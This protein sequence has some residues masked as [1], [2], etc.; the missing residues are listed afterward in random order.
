MVCKEVKTY[1]Q[2]IY[3]WVKE[4]SPAKMYF[5]RGYLEILIGTLISKM[6]TKEN[7]KEEHQI[8][9]DKYKLEKIRRRIRRVSNKVDPRIQVVMDYVVLHPAE[10]YTPQSMADMAELSKQRFSCLFKEQ[11]G[12]SPMAYIKE[13]KLTTAARKLLVCNETVRL[14]MRWDTRTR[15]TLSENLSLL[16]G[17]RPINI[18]KRRRSRD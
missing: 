10:K 16:L 3:R 11:V 14:P 2:Q 9:D 17:I 12:K 15:T 7:C 6:S 13:L 4:D 1:F 18:G 8:T 5:V